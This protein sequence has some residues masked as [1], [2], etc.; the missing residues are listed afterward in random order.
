MPLSG[1]PSRIMPD[2]SSRRGD[3]AGG[4]APFIVGT[5]VR[6]NGHAAA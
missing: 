2:E 6:W 4:R 3:L 5:S 1:V